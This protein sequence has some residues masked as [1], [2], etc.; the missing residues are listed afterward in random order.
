MQLEVIFERELELRMFQNKMY[1]VWVRVET[2]SED[3]KSI[4]MIT[5]SEDYS[6]N[7]GNNLLLLINKHLS[8]MA[9]HVSK[10]EKMQELISSMNDSGGDMFQ[11]ALIWQAKK[12]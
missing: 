2:G 9:K 5:I 8:F 1:Y 7:E 10:R 3:T 4:S 12:S 11:N 6:M